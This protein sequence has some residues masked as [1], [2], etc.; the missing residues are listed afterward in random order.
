MSTDHVTNHSRITDYIII[1]SDLCKGESC[2]VHSPVF[3]QMH[4]AAE[5][6]LELEHDEPVTPHLD[7]YVRLPTADHEVPSQAQLR[8]A[9]HVIHEMV[10]QGKNIYVH[11]RN[12]HGR[13]PTVVA[14]YFIQYEKMG[15]L[16]AVERIKSKRPEIHLEQSQMMAL[17]EFQKR[18]RINWCRRKKRKKLNR[19]ISQIR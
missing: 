14:A 19:L 3:R 18:C 7:M 13:A 9:A 11:C 8:I 12:G 2:P 6:D 10:S 4:V 15:V 1:G 5:I 16:A 17:E